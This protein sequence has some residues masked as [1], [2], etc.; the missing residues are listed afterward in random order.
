MYKLPEK[1]AWAT[2]KW[3]SSFNWQHAEAFLFAV[4]CKCNTIYSNS[5]TH[6]SRFFSVSLKFVYEMEWW[7][8]YV[9]SFKISEHELFDVDCL[10]SQLG[11][12][13]HRNNYTLNWI[14]KWKLMRWRKMRER[15]IERFLAASKSL[16]ETKC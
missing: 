1:I 7:F 4:C 11:Y 9:Y 2:C 8:F 12:G 14:R 5:L 15:E 10:S 16:C 6:R 3:R 13:S